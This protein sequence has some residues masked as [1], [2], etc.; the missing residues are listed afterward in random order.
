MKFEEAYCD[1]IKRTITLDAITGLYKTNYSLYAKSYKNSFWCP[2]CRKVRLSYNNDTPPYL[3]AYPNSLHDEYCTYRQDELP[4]EKVN[5]LVSSRRYMDV[6][7]R[8]MDS[9]MHLLFASEP[10]EKNVN[11]TPKHPTLLPKRPKGTESGNTQQIPRKRI[12][13]PLR[14]NDYDTYKLF[15]GDVTLSWEVK[16]KFCPKNKFVLRD[17]N[18]RKFICRIC[19]TDKVCPHIPSQFKNTEPYH[20]KVV[21]FGKVTRDQSGYKQNTLEHSSYLQIYPL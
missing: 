16:D 11:S 12:D 17:L 5:A 20:G 3:S 18:N 14:E 21:F 4:S 10:P 1:Y 9:L 13:T 15:Y 7:R 8:Q 2:E 19:I 6:I